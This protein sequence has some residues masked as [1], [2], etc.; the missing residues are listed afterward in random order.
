[1]KWRLLRRFLHQNYSF[2]V[3]HVNCRRTN[4][5]VHPDQLQMDSWRCTSAAIRIGTATHSSSLVR[6][7]PSE[8]R[9]PTYFSCHGRFSDHL[10][11]DELPLRNAA[12]QGPVACDERRMSQA[13]GGAA[14]AGAGRLSSFCF[15]CTS[16]MSCALVSPRRDCAETRWCTKSHF[17]SCDIVGRKVSGQGGRG[18]S[19][20][21]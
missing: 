10:E 6:L 18:N 4:A 2:L 9:A 5:A 16:R 8:P 19:A 1:M 13:E 20:S 15:D 21:T 3:S 7:R 12:R 11:L 14:A 17:F